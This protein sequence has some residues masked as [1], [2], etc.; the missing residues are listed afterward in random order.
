MNSYQSQDPPGGNQPIIYCDNVYVKIADFNTFNVTQIIN[1]KTLQNTFVTVTHDA[2]A[3][4][5]TDNGVYDHEF[6]MNF[7][8]ASGALSIEYKMC[9]AMRLYLTALK[10]VIQNEDDEINAEIK[11]GL[12]TSN[13]VIIS[14]NKL[15]RC[16][17]TVVT[18]QLWI[19]TIL[20]HWQ[21]DRS[22]DFGA[23]QGTV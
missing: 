14:L 13:A 12:S 4:S 17:G 8:N 20:K 1:H 3:L 2:I 11:N 19:Q 6:W 9:T 5:S 15:R 7:S 18:L 23:D 16:I 10:Y 22:A 21:T